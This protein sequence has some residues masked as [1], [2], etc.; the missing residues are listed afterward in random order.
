MKELISRKRGV[1]VVAAAF[2]DHL[3]V[4]LRLTVELPILW[5]GRGLWKMDDVL[6]EITGTNKLRI[7]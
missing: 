6:T 4:C 5:T 2:T 1:E 3:V 7:I